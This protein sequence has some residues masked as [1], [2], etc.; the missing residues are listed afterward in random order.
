[1]RISDLMKR[2]PRY[3]LAHET[4]R[5]AARRMRDENIGF[6]PVC[7]ADR[8]VLGTITDRDITIRVVAAGLQAEAPV[9]DVMS[10]EVV[11]CHPEDDL[12]RAEQLM[13]ASQKSRL[14]V[15]DPD[16]RLVGVVSLSDVAGHD[17]S[18][19]AETVAR[20]SKR[21]MHLPRHA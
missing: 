11:A 13:A 21:E 15:L 7:D 4:C 10:H 16:G 18:H 8:R 19:A 1:V 3:V 9:G 14:L 12:A 17:T 5:T 20:V 2:E 6:L